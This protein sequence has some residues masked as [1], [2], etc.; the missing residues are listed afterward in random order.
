MT[1]AKIRI[2]AGFLSEKKLH[3]KTA[4]QHPEHWKEKTKTKTASMFFKHKGKTKHFFRCTNA[5]RLSRDLYCKKC[6]RKVFQVERQH[7]IEIWM[8]NTQNSNHMGQYVRTF[9]YFLSIF[10]IELTFKIKIAL[11]CEFYNIWR[12]TTMAQRPGRVRR[13]CTIVRFVE[14]VKDIHYTL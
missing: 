13:K 2:T 5:E 8:K 9:A 14:H 3:M 7:Q 12:T 4:E 1:E 10:N 6:Q 11:C